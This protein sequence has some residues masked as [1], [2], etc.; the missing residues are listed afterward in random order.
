MHLDEQLALEI[1]KAIVD[2][3]SADSIAE[4]TK[5]FTETFLEVLKNVK[6]TA[7]QNP[8]VRDFN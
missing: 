2:L 1:T 7:H 8:R 4:K 5:L 3:K 6:S